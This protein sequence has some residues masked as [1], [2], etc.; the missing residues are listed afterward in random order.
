MS[1]LGTEEW[2]TENEKR[3]QKR[4]ERNRM[5]MKLDK[6]CGIS[7]LIAHLVVCVDEK[8]KANQRAWVCL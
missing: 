5:L 2:L 6:V 3:K 1:W 7:A 4:K 8:R